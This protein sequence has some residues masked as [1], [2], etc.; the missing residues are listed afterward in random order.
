MEPNGVTT[1]VIFREPKPFCPVRML[2]TGQFSNTYK[3][4]QSITKICITQLQ[5]AS[6][7][8]FTVRMLWFYC[9]LT[10][11]YYRQDSSH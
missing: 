3:I 1:P 4:T 7:T 5:V 2:V 6:S 10:V 9:V 8:I 11:A